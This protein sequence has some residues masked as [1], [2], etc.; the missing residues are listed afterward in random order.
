MSPFSRIQIEKEPEENRSE[1]TS[2]RVHP[3]Q[4]GRE[5]KEARSQETF[6]SRSPFQGFTLGRGRR[7]TAA[8][9]LVPGPKDSPWE[10]SRGRPGAR[11]RSQ[12]GPLFKASPCEEAEGG[13][14]LGD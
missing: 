9:R 10:E 12:V 8:R 1:K 2:P 5:K 6:P 7:R 3:V 13:Q 11:R 4:L 14:E